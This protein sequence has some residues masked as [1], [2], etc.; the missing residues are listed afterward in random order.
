[1]GG[2]A[3]AGALSSPQDVVDSVVSTLS[4]QSLSFKF[5]AAC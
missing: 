5:N 3:G 2:W 4:E 1:V